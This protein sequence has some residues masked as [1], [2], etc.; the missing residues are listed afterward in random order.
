MATKQTGPK[1]AKAAS[2]VLK[3]S[4]T[5]KNSKI[6][7]GS[8]LTQSKTVRESTSARAATAASQVLRDGRTSK[9]SKS[10]AGSALA[11]ARSKKKSPSG[12]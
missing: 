11:Q 9:A 2:Q 3:S 7:A 5:G 4:S 12:T 1:A 6:A 10:A 8:A